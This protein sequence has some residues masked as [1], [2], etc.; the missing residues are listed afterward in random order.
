MLNWAGFAFKCAATDF[1][2]G[3]DLINIGATAM[4]GAAQQAQAAGGVMASMSNEASYK[5]Q[6]KAFSKGADDALKEAGRVQEQGRLQR[7]SRTVQLGQQK[8]AIISSA[9][10]S[11]L[12]V[13]SRTVKKVVSDTV[14]SAYNDLDVMAENEKQAT[15]AK[16]NEQTAMKVNAIWAESNANQEKINQDLMF[17]QMELNRKSIKMQQ[18]AGAMSAASNWMNGMVGAGGSLMGGG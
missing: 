3:Q 16:I 18:I 13:S 17:N 14:K 15:Q 11:G 1:N 10:G 7:E 6:A 12:D 4:Q 2:L 9:A 5:A 8:G